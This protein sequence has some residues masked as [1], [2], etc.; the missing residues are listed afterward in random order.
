MARGRFAKGVGYFGEGFSLIRAPGLR[1][2]V[3]I[4]LVLNILAFALLFRLIYDGFSLLI[5]Q[6]MSWLPDWAWLQ[7][8]H[9]LFWLLYG[10]VVVLLLAY[11]FV[12]VANIIGA[13]FYA[14]LAEKVEERETGRRPGDDRPWWQLWLDVPR[15]IGREFLK[16]A[17]YLPRALILFL[18]GLI[19]AVNLVVGVLWFL[20]NSWMMAFQYVDYPADN[21][22]V[23]ISEL[24]NLLRRR[25]WASLGFGMPVALAAMVPVLN[26]ILVPAAVCGAT[27]FWIR[28]REGLSGDG[29]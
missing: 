20:F 14:L 24:K 13:P 18:L 11:G 26:L 28:E 25:R 7:S 15:A 8:L 1:R 12:V 3:V 9:W 6:M 23:P 27:L 29:D 4:P 21:H 19:P 22:R 16:L 5:N 17:Y 2:Y 10:V